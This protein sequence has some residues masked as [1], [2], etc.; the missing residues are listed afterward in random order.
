MYGVELNAA[1]PSARVAPYAVILIVCAVFS[2]SMGTAS[3]DFVMRFRL[4]GI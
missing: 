4:T 3:H 1:P 2:A